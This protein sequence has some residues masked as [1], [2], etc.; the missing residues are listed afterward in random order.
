MTPPVTE[1]RQGPTWSQVAK[2]ISDLVT[3][4]DGEWCGFPMPLKG[5]GLV[6]E[7][8]HPMKDTVAGVQAIVDGDVEPRAVAC[9]A[10][11]MGWHIVNSWHSSPKNG[12]ILVIHHEDGRKTWALDADLPRRNRFW[13]GP[14]ET[15]DAWNVETDMVAMM[16]L[17]DL[18]SE[19]MFAAYVLTG[20][21]LEHS[22]RS[23]LMYLFR[24]CRPTVVLTGHGARDDLFTGRVREDEM[25]ILCALCLHP[26][27]YYAN[28]F[29]GAMT[30]TDDVIAHLL[31]MR[32]DEHM[33]WKRAN[34]HHAGVPEAGL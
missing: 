3:E 15:L 7:D 2:R 32:G 26:I 6:L 21:F 11:I 34:Q 14:L 29:A 18:L 30:P 1:E 25:R 9:D 28:S 31:L 33:F 22:K 19:R 10:D 17:R 20:T 16:K 27:G 5:L 24:R 4:R 12:R 8:K 23:G 13:L